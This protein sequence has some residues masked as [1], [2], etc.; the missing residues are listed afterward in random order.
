MQTP[1]LTSNVCK[2]LPLPTN[3]Q[4]IMRLVPIFLKLSFYQGN[5]SMQRIVSAMLLKKEVK[6]RA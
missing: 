6:V 3:L 1:S 2:K 5:R 4:D